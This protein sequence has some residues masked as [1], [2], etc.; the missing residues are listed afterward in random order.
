MCQCICQVIQNQL[1]QVQGVLTNVNTNGPTLISQSGQDL[2]GIGDNPQDTGGID[3]GTI[4]TQ[5]LTALLMLILAAVFFQNRNR[6]A[7]R[8]EQRRQALLQEHPETK[9]GGGPDGPSNDDDDDDD[10]LV[11]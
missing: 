7:V 3:A 1:E 6:R 2:T 8:G 10:D 11:L 9:K 5:I 4:Q